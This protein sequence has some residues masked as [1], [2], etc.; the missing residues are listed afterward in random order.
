MID[1]K[2]N[3]LEKTDL[4]LLQQNLTSNLIPW[5]FNH[6]VA[7]GSGNMEYGFSTTVFDDNKLENPSLAYLLNPIL[8]HLNNKQLIRCRVGFIFYSGQKENEY[9]SPHVD[10][11]TEHTTSL[12]YVNNSDA[13]TVF[14]NEFYPTTAKNYTVQNT[15]KPQENTLIT[16][17]GLQYH[18]SSS[19]RQ[20][21]YRFV[22]TFN[23]R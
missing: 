3:V 16:F 14:Y 8:E 21:G 11:E 9:H 12:F 15:V 22:I 23:Y 5:T 19:P 13:P 6:N 20:P 7:Y 17:N 18:S 4:L 10:F 2:E 1:I